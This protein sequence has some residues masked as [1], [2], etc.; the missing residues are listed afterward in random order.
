MATTPESSRDIKADGA[1]PAPALHYL[2]SAGATRPRTRLDRAG[3]ARARPRRVA[4]A[5]LDRADARA[6]V[7]AAARR[8]R[9]AGARPRARP[10]ARAAGP[11]GRHAH[12]GGSFTCWGWPPC[13][14]CCCSAASRK[15]ATRCACRR[16]PNAR[17]AQRHAGPWAPIS[18]LL[19][20][21]EANDLAAAGPLADPFG[22]VDAVLAAWTGGLAARTDPRDFGRCPGQSMT[23]ASSAPIRPLRRSFHRVVRGLVRPIRGVERPL[24]GQRSQRVG[25]AERGR[26]GRRPRRRACWC[27]VPR[28]RHGSSGRSSCR[29]TKAVAPGR[30]RILPDLSEGPDRRCC[31]HCSRLDWR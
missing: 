10:H 21:L 26:P 6:P 29:P 24:P 16:M 30:L 27:R 19:E 12:P 17:A 25:V 3:R 4:G 31:W 18:I 15:P 23:R 13:C 11:G 20:A 14:R 8:R 22:G 2:N 5:P 7:A 1:V 28:R 9:P